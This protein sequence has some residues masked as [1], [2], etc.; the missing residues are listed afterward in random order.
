MAL[1]LSLL[2]TVALGQDYSTWKDCNSV[3]S[4]YIPCCNR[5]RLEAQLAC[6][7][8]SNF[9]F[10]ERTCLPWLEAIET[11]CLLVCGDCWELGRRLRQ[12]C[13]FQLQ[14]LN[15]PETTR[16]WCNDTLNDFVALRCTPAC[17][18]NETECATQKAEDC[19]KKCG[20]YNTCQ[21]RGYKGSLLEPT[22]GGVTFSD[23]AVDPRPDLYYDCALTPA[24]CKHTSYDVEC[25]RYRYCPPNLCLIEDVQCDPRHQCEA[26]G[27]CDPEKGLCFYQNRDDGYPCNDDIFYTLNDSCQDGACVGIPDY[28]LGYNVSCIP[29]NPC[30]VDGACNPSTGRCTYSQLPDETPC[31]DGRMYTVQ[32]MCQNGLC[33]GRPQDLCEQFGVVCEAPNWCYDPGV[34][35]PK[36][37]TCSEATLAPGFRT[38]NDQDRT[39]YNDTCIEGVCMGI[40]DTGYKYQTMGAGECV[41]RQ[42]RRMA[43]YTGDVKEQSECEA[44]CTGDPQCA[45]YAYNYPLCSIYG[46]VRTKLPLERQAWSFQ[47][48]TDPV[49]VII[50]K[51]L[52]LSNVQRRSICRKKGVEGDT[53]ASPSD[54][55]V[56]ADEF[57]S[58]VRIG[59]FFLL[60]LAC[61][62]ALPLTDYISRLL[63]CRKDPL[64]DLAG[65]VQQDPAYVD[66]ADAQWNDY[67]DDQLELKD[68]FQDDLRRAGGQNPDED[69]LAF[70]PDEHLPVPPPETPPNPPG[71][72]EGEG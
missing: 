36:T 11:H 38:C 6:L 56:S 67:G 42:D 68:G 13:Q 49:A 63:K 45:G 24:D 2:G 69:A 55:E 48:G 3:V 46:T 23:G 18:V 32:D 25:N 35:D 30:L 54:L 72:V 39:T 60:V 52:V 5:L 53:I 61:F 58:P 71:R 26:P 57:F 40:L 50:E 12:E 29:L 28:C 70:P 22:C 4:N 44:I 59:I 34:C 21:C 43:R 15:E 7:E 51:A 37:G 14:V 9:G 33:V 31:D 16:V 65:Q 19:M 27:S 20:N 47:A 8:Y 1:L 41:D 62:F 17:L 66:G 64:E 10:T